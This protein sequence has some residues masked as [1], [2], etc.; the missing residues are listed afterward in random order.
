M[1]MPFAETL[2]STRYI[3]KIHDLVEGGSSADR[4][5]AAWQS[6]GESVAAVVDHIVSESTDL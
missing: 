1:V 2:H 6:S 5:I 4:Q 3:E